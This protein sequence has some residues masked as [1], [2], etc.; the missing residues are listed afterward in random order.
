MTAFDYEPLWN[1]S[2]IFVDRA[3]RAR[4]NHDS[5][6]FHLWSSIALELLGK[7]ALAAIHPTLVADPSDIDSMLTAAGRATGTTRRSITAKTLYDRLGKVVPEF[8]ERLKRE[9]MLMANRRNAEL[10]SG[11]SPI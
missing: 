11:E 10:H 2:K 3:I 1:K 8:E 4:D 7:A 6:D 5:T 9:S